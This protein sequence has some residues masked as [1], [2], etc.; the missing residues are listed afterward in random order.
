LDLRDRPVLTDSILDGFV[1]A[2]VPRKGLDMPITGLSPLDEFLAHD[3]EKYLLGDLAQ[4]T[5]DD[6]IQRRFIRVACAVDGVVNRDSVNKRLAELI[7]RY[8]KDARPH[9]LAV[10]FPLRPTT[11]TSVTVSTAVAISDPFGVSEE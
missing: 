9:N 7:R 8:N 2:R 4:M 10:T 11:S 1:A 6:V 5:R 3:V